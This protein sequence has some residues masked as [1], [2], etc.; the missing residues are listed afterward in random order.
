[1][2]ANSGELLIMTTMSDRHLA[3]QF[4]R[5]LVERRL[6]ACVSRFRGGISVYWWE[7]DEPTEEAEVLLLIKTHRDKLE[8]IEAYF[9]S[10][11]PYEVPEILCLE[12]DRISKPYRD[13]LRREMKLKSE[14]S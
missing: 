1:M 12:P 14:T 13:W 2:E 8:A 4:A 11:H 6:A 5:D 9:D 7:G 10:E 3:R